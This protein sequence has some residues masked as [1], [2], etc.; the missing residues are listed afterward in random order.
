MAKVNI[1]KLVHRS[2]QG[3]LRARKALYGQLA[4]MMLSVAHRYANGAADAEDIFQESVVHI[5]EKLHQLKEAD[6]IGGW[7]KKIVTNEA[8]R[9]YHKKRKLYFDSDEQFIANSLKENDNS[10]YKKIE[11]NELLNIIQQLPEKMRLAL[12]LYAIEGYKHEEIAEMLH[13]SVGT[14]KSNLHDA[15]ARVKEFIKAEKRKLG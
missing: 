15:R 5:F 13:I 2:I 6:R 10:I 1:H 14:S 7:A 3:D 12:N 8:I 11:V 4:P 9:Y